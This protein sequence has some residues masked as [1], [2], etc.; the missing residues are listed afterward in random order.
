M[1]GDQWICK[2]GTHNFIERKKCRSCGKPKEE[3]I[4]EEDWITVMDRVTE[5]SMASI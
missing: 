4:S 3:A 5:Q 1:W 2:C